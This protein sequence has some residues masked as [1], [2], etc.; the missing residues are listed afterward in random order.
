VS[1]DSRVFFGS[2]SGSVYEYETGT[3]TVKVCCKLPGK[4]TNRIAISGGGQNFFILTCSNQ[5]FALK[6]ERTQT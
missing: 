3:S 2:I 1:V 5:L 4:I 6:R